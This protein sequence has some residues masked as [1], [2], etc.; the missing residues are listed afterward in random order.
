MLE[1][2]GILLN[3]AGTALGIIGAIFNALGQRIAFP[4]WILSNILLL[5]LFVGIYIKKWKLNS[6]ALCQI[7]L[8]TLYTFTSAYGTIRTFG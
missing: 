2:I 7:G 1:K 3:L 8:Y 6:G 4:L 5:T